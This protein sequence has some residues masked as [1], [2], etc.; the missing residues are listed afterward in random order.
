MRFSEDMAGS[1]SLRRLDHRASQER[2]EL[3]PELLPYRRMKRALVLSRLPDLDPGEHGRPASHTACPAIPGS[4]EKTGS[5]P[6]Q[7]CAV[8]KK[9]ARAAVPASA[10]VRRPAP[11]KRAS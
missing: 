10:C 9:R 7:R 5:C 3:P 6:H 8:D 11:W 2:E 4:S 1:I